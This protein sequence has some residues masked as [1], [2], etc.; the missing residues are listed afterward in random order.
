VI[1]P[2]EEIDQPVVHIDWQIF[3][4]R[5]EC[6]TVSRALLKPTK[7]TVTDGLKRSMF[8]MVLCREIIAAIG[9]PVGRNANWSEKE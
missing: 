4:R 5:V 3:S 2:T 1:V 9:E 8:V 7:M 6:H